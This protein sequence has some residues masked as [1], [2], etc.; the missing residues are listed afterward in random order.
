MTSEL[1]RS[2]EQEGF[3]RTE[4]IACLGGLVLLLM[5][6]TPTLGTSASRADRVACFNNL[7]H[8]GNAFRQYALE[9]NDSPPWS[10]WAP[11]GNYNEP[12]KHEL[13][14]RCWW[15]RDGMGSPTYL[16][17]PAETR[18]SAR[19]ATN[20]ELD[21]GRGVQTLKN[22]AVSYVLGLDSATFLPRSIIVADRHILDVGYGGCS[23]GI[24]PAAQLPTLPNP[25]VRWTTEV[26]G[27]FG[28]VALADGSVESVDSDGLR[29]TVSE[30]RDLNA[31]VHIMKGN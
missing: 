25:T 29:R 14:F 7:R 16:M 22:R 9:N 31:T 6:I 15:I 23:S 19:V 13:W 5:V 24:S 27:E 4:L 26:H 1:M 10:R 2:H 18:T 30:V 11:T 17:K 8:L 12:G 28:N 3:T 20:W 21:G